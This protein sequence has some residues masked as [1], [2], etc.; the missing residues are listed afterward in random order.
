MCGTLTGQRYVDD[1][2]RPHVGPFLS[3]LPGA[4][5]QQD[6]ARPHTAR[7]LKTSYP[8]NQLPIHILCH[9]GRSSASATLSMLLRSGGKDMRLIKDKNS[10]LMIPSNK[11]VLQKLEKKICMFRP[12]PGHS[13]GIP[14]TSCKDEHSSGRPNEGTTLEMVKKIHKAV[15]DDRRQKVHELEDIVGI[16]NSAVHCILSEN[17]DM[18][19]LCAR[20][21]RRFLAIIFIDYLEKGK[22]VNCE[23]CTNLLQQLSEEIK[24]KQAHLAKKKVL[25][26]QDNAPALKPVIAIA[27]INEL[28]FELLPDAPYS[29]DLAPSDYF[30]FSNMK[31]W[32]SGQRSSNDEEV[33]SAVNGYFE[34]QDSSYYK[35]GTELIEHHSEKYVQL[36]GDY[37]ER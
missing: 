19:K 10:L 27:K 32:L 30:L 9:K 21:W 12:Y 5:F 7:V 22:T 28:K 37:V 26:H 13:S 4:I 8:K 34:E 33:I 2:L 3:G 29:P 25:F 31:K 16:S 36:K 15:L 14:K 6:N 1:I 23:Y 20:S 18:R 11:R 24:Q 17:L 35:K